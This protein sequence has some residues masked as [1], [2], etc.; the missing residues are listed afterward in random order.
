MVTLKDFN[1]QNHEGR[2]RQI[3]FE[4]LIGGKLLFLMNYL[5][6][7]STIPQIK[8][9]YVTSSPIFISGPRGDK[10]EI[11]GNNCSENVGMFGGVVHIELLEEG[12]ELNITL[13]RNR[14]D[15]NM[16][17][18]E[19]NAIFIKG[20]HFRTITI[21]SSRFTRNFGLTAGIGAAISI[22]G[23]DNLSH[24]F[25]LIFGIPLSTEARPSALSIRYNS[26][27]QNYAGQLGSAVNVQRID[28]AKLVLSGNRFFNNT[29]AFSLFEE[30]H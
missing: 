28:K 17:Y 5:D 22:D 24:L 4:K 12:S 1:H 13:A 2:P 23:Q 11:S 18:F 27:E 20:S 15:R 8:E 25:G 30:E 14:F 16:A 21:E 29:G 10:I 26:F 19:G 3:N 6:P 7:S 9:N